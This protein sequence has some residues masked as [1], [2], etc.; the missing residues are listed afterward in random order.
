MTIERITSIDLLKGIGIILVMLGHALPH[1][2]FIRTLIY[3]FHMPLFFWCSGFFYR[4]KPIKEVTIKDIKSLL[5]P[6]LMF[7]VFLV[8][9]ACVL[10]YKDGQYS[11]LQFNLLDENS[12]CLFHTIW[13]LPCLFLVRIFYRAIADL[14]HNKTM[15][16]IS[17][18]GGYFCSFLLRNH[19]I[20]IPLFLDSV[21]S[22]LLFYHLGRVFHERRYNETDVNTMVLAIMLI[23]YSALVY[24][25]QPEVNIKDNLFPIYL[26][27]MSMVPIVALFFLCKKINSKFL[28]RCG[29]A[30]LVIMGLHHPIYDVA[31]FPL[32]NR[33]PLP[34]SAEPYIMV[35]ILLPIL[36]V[37]E[38]LIMKYCPWI[39][40]KF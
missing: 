30:S 31:L 38:K 4:N 14:T 12:Y 26:V 21:L 8:M 17:V 23:A 27:V 39:M 32:M 16:P 7:C 5:I 15:I 20:N 9:C 40:G 13:F 2:N 18:W 37:V 36:L 35:A 25:I 3:T 19:N 24:W 6:W 34:T 29:A 22:M 11:L 10:G 28:M 33:L 1:D